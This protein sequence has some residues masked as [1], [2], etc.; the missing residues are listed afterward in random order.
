MSVKIQE[1]CRVAFVIGSRLSHAREGKSFSQPSSFASRYA[2]G[3]A[4]RNGACLK[5]SGG[6]SGDEI[7]GQEVARGEEGG[8]ERVRKPRERKRERQ[9]RCKPLGH[10]GFRGKKKTRFR[11][12]RRCCA[13]AGWR[14]RGRLAVSGCPALA[15]DHGDCQEACKKMGAGE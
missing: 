8:E 14:R 2:I 7:G 12:A 13:G 5:S 4:Q 1:K 6:R 3:R 15:T 11:V 9:R 10:G